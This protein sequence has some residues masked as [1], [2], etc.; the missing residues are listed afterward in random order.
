MAA[1]NNNIFFDLIEEDVG[2]VYVSVMAGGEE[3]CI[4]LLKSG[5]IF[6]PNKQLSIISVASLSR[7]RKE[8]LYKN[9]RQHVEDPFKN[10]H[11]SK[12]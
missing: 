3:T 6:D 12:P 11:F 4:K 2:K 5:T 1:E 8:Y 10:V 9:I 7:D